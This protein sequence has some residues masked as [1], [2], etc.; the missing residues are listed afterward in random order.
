MNISQI[1]EINKSAWDNR[2]IDLRQSFDF[3]MKTKE[4]SSAL[5]YSKGL[6][7]SSKVLGY[8]YWRFSDY[9]QSLSNSLT[10][11]KIY[12]GLNAQKDEADTLNSIGAVYMFQ[13]ENI[14]RLECNLQCLK[15]RQDV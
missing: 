10:A 2:R 14:K 6:A 15:I 7:D 3:A 13:N 4:A 8:C 5:K 12:K 9:S 11:L 1:D